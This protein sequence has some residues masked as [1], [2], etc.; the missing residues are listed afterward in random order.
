MQL[1][2]AAH[3]TSHHISSRWTDDRPMAR[4]LSMGFLFNSLNADIDGFEVFALR[5]KHMNLCTYPGAAPFHILSNSYELG[6]SQQIIL[7]PDD[8]RWTS[9]FFFIRF[10]LGVWHG[11]ENQ[12]LRASGVTA[13]HKQMHIAMCF[14]HT[15]DMCYG[16]GA[17]GR[18]RN[19]DSKYCRPQLDQN[20]NFNQ[21]FCISILVVFI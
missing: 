13:K 8:G 20:R 1:L 10:R 14:R 16:S 18:P 11:R 12:H 19:I 4:T 6:S 21:I 5:C 2:H 9:R 15:V 3:V 7:N 17:G